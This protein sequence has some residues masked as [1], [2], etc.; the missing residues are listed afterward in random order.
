MV[1][2]ELSE[3]HLASNTCGE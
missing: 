2:Q 1:K 3:K